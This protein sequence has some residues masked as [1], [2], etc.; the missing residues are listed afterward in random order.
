VNGEITSLEAKMESAVKHIVFERSNP[1]IEVAKSDLQKY[2]G[3]Y[4]LEGMNVKLYIRGEKTLMLLVPGQPDYE[5]VPTAED[6]FDLKSIAGYS[7]KF[8]VKDAEVKSISFIQ[9]NGTFKANKKK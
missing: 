5:L 9:P 7:V 8:E 6:A 3:E 4:D 2:V 1:A